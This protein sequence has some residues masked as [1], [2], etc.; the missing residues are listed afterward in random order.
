M[1]SHQLGQNLWYLHWIDDFS[2]FSNAVIIKS[3]ST[4][5]IIKIFLEYRIS[6]FVSPNTVFSDDGGEFLSKEFIDFYENFNMKLKT[7]AAE[8][9]LE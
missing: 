3:S 6:L 8:S 2:G 9:S 7:T 4:D 1:D 5:I